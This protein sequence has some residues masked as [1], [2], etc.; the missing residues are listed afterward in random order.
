[1]DPDVNLAEQRSLSGEIV[2]MVDADGFE[3]DDTLREGV[4]ERA[5]RLA[6]LCE[7]LDQWIL[8]QGALPREWYEKQ[9]LNLNTSTT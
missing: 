7:A 8:R 9:K 6:E 4:I 5:V 3:T 2:S 1:M